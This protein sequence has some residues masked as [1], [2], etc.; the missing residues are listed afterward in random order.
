MVNVC[1]PAVIVPERDEPVLAATE[2]PT[3]PLPVPDEPDVTVI[4]V[5]L[6]AAVHEQAEL[7]GVT[8][9][10]PVPPEAVALT[11]VAPSE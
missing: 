2:Y 4:Q 5:L 11:D 8:V 10:V 1:P 6:D 3:V 7:P 9:K